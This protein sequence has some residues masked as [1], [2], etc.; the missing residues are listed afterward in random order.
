MQNLRRLASAGTVAALLA[1]LTV[2]ASADGATYYAC[3]KKKGGAIR[4]VAAR[5]HCKR[6]ERKISFDS[7]GAPGKN[8]TNGRDGRDGRDGANGVNGTNGATGFTST[9]PKG[10]SEMGTWGALPNG[11]AAGY[12]AISFTIP[13]A[14]APAV[15]VTEA[16]PEGP[17]PPCLGTVAKPTAEPGHLCI[18][19]D[20]RH[21][22]GS[23]GTL[24]PVTGEE[25]AEAFGTLVSVSFSAMDG[26]WAVTG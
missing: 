3:V 7:T 2:A 14:S 17:K 23:V 1:T 12:S 24:D 26:T 16:T 13:L 19:I 21:F 5:A 25:G 8:G 20:T 15:T 11:A 6:S 22:G 4:L 18:Y 9:L 10:Q